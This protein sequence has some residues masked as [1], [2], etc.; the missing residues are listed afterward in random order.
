MG[1]NLRNPTLVQDRVG[2]HSKKEN[3]SQNKPLGVLCLTHQHHIMK[4][5]LYFPLHQNQAQVFQGQI[6][7]R[8][9]RKGLTDFQHPDR[10]AD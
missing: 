9:R 4:R 1:I 3:L 10:G 6:L 8:D 7:V 2:T 5:L